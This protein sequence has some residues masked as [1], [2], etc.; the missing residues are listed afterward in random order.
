[1]RLGTYIRLRRRAEVQMEHRNG[2]GDLSD[3]E[4][5]VAVGETWAGL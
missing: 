3:F 5:S 2:E 1:M 4:C